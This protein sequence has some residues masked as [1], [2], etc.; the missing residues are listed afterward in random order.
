MDRITVYQ[1]WKLKSHSLRL[2]AAEEARIIKAVFDA[3]R[4]REV[5]NVFSVCIPVNDKENQGLGVG[6]KVISGRMLAIS[7]LLRPGGTPGAAENAGLQLGDLVFG[8]NFKACRDGPE[9]LTDEL[10]SSRNGSGVLHLQCLR[11]ASL[12]SVPCPGT[13]LS[14]ANSVVA[15]AYTLT[16]STKGS[17][18]F[19]EEEMWNFIDVIVKYLQPMVLH[20][21]EDATSESSMS[22]YALQ[23]LLD[24]ES[25]ILKAKGMRMALVLRLLSYGSGGDGM[26]Y[27]FYVEDVETGSVWRKAMYSRELAVLHEELCDICGHATSVGFPTNL[28]ARL[29]M[30]FSVT[31]KKETEQNQAQ[32]LESYLRAMLTTLQLY[33]PGDASASKALRRVQSFLDVDNY[34]EN[35]GINPLEP[36]RE[37]ELMAFRVL[38]DA[39]SPLSQ[40]CQSFVESWQ[41]ESYIDEQ[42]PGTYKMSLK[43]LGEALRETEARLRQD[44][45]MAAM[46]LLTK[47]RP[48]L[49]RD[50][51]KI[52]VRRCLRRQVELAIYLPF[53]Q[54]IWDILTSELAQPCHALASCMEKVRA[55]STTELGVIQEVVLA[56]CLPHAVKGMRSALNA[57]LPMDHLLLLEDAATTIMELHKQARELAADRTEMLEQQKQQAG[58]L[59]RAVLAM[60]RSGFSQE[61]RAPDALTF[62]KDHQH[63]LAADDFIPIFTYVLVQSTLPQLVMV[64]EI[65]TELADQQESMEETGY[66]MATLEAAV[67]HIKELA[68]GFGGAANHVKSPSMPPLPVAISSYPSSSQ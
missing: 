64:Q 61:L 65:I 37:L 35:T 53:R 34:V 13:S 22:S 14:V 19:S 5:G 44:C 2:C 42:K 46:A 40:S 63:T 62:K 6:V 33:A 41:P 36:Q 50:Q 47:R 57:I 11:C 52:A 58:T 54:R 26:Q 21:Q 43:V 68:N 66:Y 7:V 38:N 60:R 59:D 31:K 67:A 23:G 27:T 30:F 8:A 49:T 55:D 29:S 32:A 17:S 51:C 48:D 18:I 12:C 20:D 9:T 15:K 28:I 3:S 45:G 39:D 24:M 16:R 56:P 10:I 1:E 25:N 4:G